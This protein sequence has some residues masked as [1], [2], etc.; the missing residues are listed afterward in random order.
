MTNEALHYA[1]IESSTDKYIV[2]YDGKIVAESEK[3]QILREHNKGKSYAPVIY[4]PRDAL[5]FTTLLKTNHETYC[6][7]K[8]EA[9]YWTLLEVE[10]A[11]WSY[12]D[13]MQE[14]LAIKSYIAFD[15]NKGFEVIVKI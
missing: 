5:D 4:F 6:P 2:K 12:E 10:N 13:P 1:V 9:N 15:K 3:V 14:L 11:V 8:G 7:I